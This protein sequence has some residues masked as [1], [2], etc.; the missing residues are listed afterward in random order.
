MESFFDV[1]PP[2]VLV[3][4]TGVAFLAGVVKGVVGFAMPMIIISGL[5][6]V[7]APGL[8]LAGLILPTLVTNGMQALRQGPAAAIAT[9]HRFRWFLGAG[10]LAMVS[11]A[12]LVTFLPGQVMMALIGIPVAA[13]ALAQLLGWQARMNRTPTRRF[14]VTFGAFTG[15]VGGLAGIWGP[16]TVAYLTALNTEKR[17]QMRVQGVIYG[18][19]AVALTLAHMVSG[20]L[21]PVTMLFSLS[22]IPPAVLGMWIGGKIQDRIDH[23]TFRK[24]TLAVLLVGG[25]NLVRR[26]FLG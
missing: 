1:F 23:A 16:P 3:L 5:S 13:F 12:Q 21:Y 6:S 26:A 4:A 17:E 8:A 22:M 11:A 19:G 9:V 20:V 18:L 2:I 24:A 14:E 7:M 10:L 15:L 25:L